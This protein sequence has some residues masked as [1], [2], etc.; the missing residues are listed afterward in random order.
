VHDAKNAAERIR[1]FIAGQV[2]LSGRG[3][4]VIGISG[5]IDSAVVAD[6]CVRV[7]QKSRVR[8]LLMPYGQQPLGDSKLVCKHLGIKYHTIQI[9]GA[10]DDLAKWT[11]SFE[12][13]PL[14]NIQARVRMT[15]E[16][17]FANLNNLLVV[18]TTNRSELLTGYFTKYGDGGCDFE[19]IAHL[20][21]TE[22]WKLAEYLHLP[23]KIIMKQ[24]SADLWDGQR[25]E[26]ELGLPYKKLDKILDFLIIKEDIASLDY[27]Y[28]HPDTPVKTLHISEEEIKHVIRMMINA[29]HKLKMP[30]K[31]PRINA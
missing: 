14:G 26:D 3:G 31:L 8:A 30:P 28:H 6:L 11:S 7:L 1:N 23:K 16:Y 17:A 12:K 19:P 4:V 21:K 27:Y 24:P 9:Q 5:G 10:V 20:Y 2:V 22:V 18:G 25:D 29:R 15:V 13:V